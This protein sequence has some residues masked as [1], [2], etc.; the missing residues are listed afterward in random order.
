MDRT[1]FAGRVKSLR[2]R[3]QPGGLGRLARRTVLVAIAMGLVG[4][5]QHRVLDGPPLQVHK[6]FSGEKF[7]YNSP[8]EQ[9]VWDWFSLDPA[10]ASTLESHPE[11]LDEARKAKPFRTAYWIAGVGSVVFS[12]KSLFTSIS[13]TND[14]TSNDIEDTKKD[15][16]ISAGFLAGMMVFDAFARRYV[17]RAVSLFNADERENGD[18]Q[19]VSRS[20]FRNVRL[21]PMYRPDT[22]TGLFVRIPLP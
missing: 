8:A 1:P 14:I 17:N 9:P 18:Q 12:F 20:L 2:K 16:A 21:S 4:C 13:S 3:R 15:L 11:S 10:F 6:Q 19:D 22:G 5:A 7:T